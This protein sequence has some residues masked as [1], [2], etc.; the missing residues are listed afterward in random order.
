M[1]KRS[2]AFWGNVAVAIA[3]AVLLAVVAIGGGLS[4][5]MSSWSWNDVRSLPD[6]VSWRK[7]GAQRQP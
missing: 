7:G 3:V 6:D 5:F 4:G 1:K 2:D